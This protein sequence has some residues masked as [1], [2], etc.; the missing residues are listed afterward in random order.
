MLGDPGARDSHVGQ[1]VR[2]VS[3]HRRR[4]GQDIGGAGMNTVTTEAPVY[5]D[6]DTLERTPK[7]SAEWFR[8]TARKDAVV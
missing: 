2:T 6:V 1:P 5:V 3:R 8:Q 4:P 7:L